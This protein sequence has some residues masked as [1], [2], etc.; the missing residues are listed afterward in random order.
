MNLTVPRYIGC[1]DCGQQVRPDLMARHTRDTGAATVCPPDACPG[2]FA[3]R[4][5]R[6]AP[7]AFDIDPP[8][9]PHDPDLERKHWEHRC[10][11]PTVWAAGWHP[12]AAA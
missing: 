8:E 11:S 9:L 2:L 7:H 4:N 10:V 3:R 12:E 6:T 5:R 1:V